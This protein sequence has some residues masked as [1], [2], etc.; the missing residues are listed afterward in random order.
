MN[1]V[2]V[3]TISTTTK[4][5]VCVCVC[6]FLGQFETDLDA[7]WHKI[8]FWYWKSSKT[9]IFGKTKKKTVYG[10]PKKKHHFGRFGKISRPN[11]NRFRR[12]FAQSCVLVL[13][14]FSTYNCWENS[15]YP[16]S[17]LKKH[18]RMRCVFLTPIPGFLSFPNNCV[19]RP[20]QD[21]N[22]TWCK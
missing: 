8:A 2:F 17:V 13:E 1:S 15:K 4:M 21:Q 14:R 5:C 20:L 3:V 12:L 9:T 10:V 6:I 22:A 19:W 11:G 18:S 7:L 16:D